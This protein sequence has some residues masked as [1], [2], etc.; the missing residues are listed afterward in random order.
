MVVS[1]LNWSH[2]K[3][4]FVNFRCIVS[5][6]L[7]IV[8]QFGNHSTE[9][10]STHERRRQ[11]NND[12]RHKTSLHSRNCPKIKPSILYALYELNNWLSYVWCQLSVLRP[13]IMS[14]IKR[15]TWFYSRLSLNYSKVSFGMRWRDWCGQSLSLLEVFLVRHSHSCGTSPLA[16][17]V[18]IIFLNYF[19]LHFLNEPL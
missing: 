16:M 17:G 10:Y 13:C 2:C 6:L 7:I 1:P 4:S 15:N 12:L 3:A 5:I 18:M 14:K 9:Q 19:I 11:V 8:V